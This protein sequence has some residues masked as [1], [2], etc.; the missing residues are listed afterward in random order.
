MSGSVEDGGVAII[1][2]P[3]YLP[4]FDKGWWTVLLQRDKHSNTLTM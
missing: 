4:F 3:I 2:D 1:S